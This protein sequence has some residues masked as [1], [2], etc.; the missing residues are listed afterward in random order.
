LKSIRFISCLIIFIFRNS[1]RKLWEASCKT[2]KFFCFWF[3]SYDLGP[4]MDLG[5]VHF[6]VVNF[7]NVQTWLKD[8]S[9]QDASRDMANCLFLIISNLVVF[10]RHAESCQF[11]AFL[12]SYFYRRILL[13][14]GVLPI[15]G[16]HNQ[17]NI[18]S[19]FR[20]DYYLKEL[21]HGSIQLFIIWNFEW[22]HYIWEANT[23]S[24]S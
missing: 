23:V 12:N 3:S 17:S 21:N 7:P 18:F 10:Y 8:Y 14:R 2:A 11:V 9:G 1:L 15:C 16:I 13:T 6:G 5:K 24:R 20:D 22:C 19:P 4:C